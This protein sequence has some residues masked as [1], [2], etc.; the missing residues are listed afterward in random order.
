MNR[1]T[2]T[3]ES[4]VT[5]LLILAAVAVLAAVPPAARAQGDSP[6]R[7]TVTLSDPAKPAFLKVNLMHGTIRV[8]AHQG[9]EVIVEAR[10]LDGEE[11]HDEHRDVDDDRIAKRK[12]MRRIT[13][14]SSGLTVEEDHN[15]VTVGAGWRNIGR[16][17]SLTVLVPPSSSMKLSTLNDGEISVEGVRGD[18]ELSNLNGPISA[19]GVSGSVV[20][21]AMNDDIRVTFT[22]LDP[23]KPMSF[24]SMNGD[25]DVTLPAA[26]KAT[27]RMKNDQGEIFSDFDM[28]MDNT[29]SRVEDRKGRGRFKVTLEK[30]MSG[31]IN[32][33]GSEIT[34]KN[35]NG[36]IYIR[37][38]K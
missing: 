16:P 5:L 15:E 14:T 28:K 11:M 26:A 27:L 23:K 9:K 29:T 32:G 33:G 36:D 24:S 31:T 38:G 21:D 20:A 3:G 17:L 30:M 37:K 19:T 2:L 22:D 8:K 13:N 4:A 10:P 1:P 25:I 35:F 34:L 6:D 7:I 18:L 12:G